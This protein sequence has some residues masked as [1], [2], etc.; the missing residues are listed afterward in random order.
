MSNK[1]TTVK[2]I[3]KAEK[4]ALNLDT[5]LDTCPNDWSKVKP[6]KVDKPLQSAIK[7]LPELKGFEVWLAPFKTPDKPYRVAPKHSFIIV[8]IVTWGKKY[9]VKSGKVKA[10]KIAELIG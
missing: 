4:S 3:K 1:K 10:L 9:L 8:H 7:G 6:L 5:L 2:T